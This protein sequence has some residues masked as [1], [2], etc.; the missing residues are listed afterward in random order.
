MSHVRLLALLLAALGLAGAAAARG[1]AGGGDPSTPTGPLL[2]A[3]VFTTADGATVQL[4]VEVAD[5]GSETQCG[6]MY[7]TEMPEDQGM[8]FVS[9]FGSFGSFWNK[10]TFIPL[11]VAYI[12]A[13]GIILD[14]VE[15]EPIEPGALPTIQEPNLRTGSGARYVI[16]ANQGWFARNEIA[17]GD[18]AHIADAVEAADAAAPPPVSPC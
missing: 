17:L 7:R 5:D 11:S 12:D 8:L 3:V 1:A 18:H 6:L 15:M 13:D 9:R 4:F 10:N 2:P 14:I 16:E